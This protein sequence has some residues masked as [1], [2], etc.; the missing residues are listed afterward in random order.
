MNRITISVVGI[1]ALVAISTAAKAEDGCGRGRFYNGERCVPQDERGPQYYEP[2][3]R[4]YEPEARRYY[5]PEAEP[6]YES[7]PEPRYYEPEP[8]VAGPRFDLGRR[9]EPQFS[10]PNPAFKTWNNCPPLYTVQDGLC[11][12]YKGR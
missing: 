4:H 7:R 11:K 3:R 2:R 6:R 8:P 9:D 1:A 12:P 5:E 10:P